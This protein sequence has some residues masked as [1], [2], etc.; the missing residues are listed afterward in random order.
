MSH[1]YPDSS[2][3]KFR[4]PR[5]RTSRFRTPRSARA[6]DI[7]A[8]ARAILETE[9]PDALT[10][11]RLGDALGMRAPS[12]YKH[13]ADKAGV[14]SAL[15]EEGLREIGEALHRVASR[16]GQ[17]GAITRLLK[18]YRFYSVGHPNLYRLATGGRLAREAL[19]TGLEDWAGEP[20]FL[21]TG[22]PY[23]A[24]AMWSFAHG[25]VILEIDGRFPEGSDLDRTWRAGA[26]AFTRDYELA[27]PA[28]RPH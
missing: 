6:L 9:G 3:P 24:Q 25:M 17:R 4:T 26:A 28:V 15:I 2:T 14:E 12:L 1:A 10:M 11:R 13:F 21:C 27:S 22:D 16:P 7:I 8:A 18:T 5:F 20:F 23:R 19:P